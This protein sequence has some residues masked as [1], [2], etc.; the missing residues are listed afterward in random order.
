MVSRLEKEIPRKLNNFPLRK[1]IALSI[2]SALA[3]K[4]H[5]AKEAFLT[6]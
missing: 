3:Q 4:F 2:M 5:R 6:I 1:K